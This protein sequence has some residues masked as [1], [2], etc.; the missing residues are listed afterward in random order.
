MRNVLNE[1]LPTWHLPSQICHLTI[2]LCDKDA[3][4]NI[5]N[6]VHQLHIVAPELSSVEGNAS[7]QTSN[8]FK[9]LSPVRLHS[10]GV[11]PFF[12]VA[13]DERRNNKQKKKRKEG[14]LFPYL[15]PATSLLPLHFL[16]LEREN[17]GLRRSCTL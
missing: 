10:T 13:G 8:A 11:P 9:S 17:I 2:L 15:K 7:L 16:P 14:F 5:R 4:K 3:S 12:S 6:W 1:F